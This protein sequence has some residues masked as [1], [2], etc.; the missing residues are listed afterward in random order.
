MILPNATGIYA[1]NKIKYDATGHD[2]W[3]ENLPTKIRTSWTVRNEFD[4]ANSWKMQERK[5][6]IAIFWI[7]DGKMKIDATI[8]IIFN[9]F[10]VDMCTLQR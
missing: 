1:C 7:C 2:F 6:Q 8:F 9:A 3:V 4:Q 5:K 10:V